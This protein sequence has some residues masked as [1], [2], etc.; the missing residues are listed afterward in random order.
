MRIRDI[1]EIFAVVLFFIFALFPTRVDG[2]AGRGKTSFRGKRGFSP[3]HTPPLF[4]KSEVFLVL[5][6]C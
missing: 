2:I 6:H 5:Y 3:P 1:V 4:E